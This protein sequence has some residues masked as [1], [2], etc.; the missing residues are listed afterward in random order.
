M[1]RS[2]AL[3]LLFVLACVLVAL[4]SSAEEVS[5]SGYDRLWSHVRLYAGDEGSFFQS[6]DLSGR[7]QL[8]WAYVRSDEESHVEFNVRRFRFGFRT[9]F[10]ED[11]T[12]HL[13]GEFNPQEADPVYTRITDGYLAW[14]PG[15]QAKVTLGKHS[16]GF[17][18]D[19]MTSSK[20]L[21]T[22]D[23]SNLTN[24][25]WF[26]EEYIPGVS[27][28][29]ESG[30]WNYFAGIFSSG[31]ETPEF[32]DLDGGQ[33]VLLTLGYDFAEALG[34]E[35][36]HLRGN[37]VDNEPESDDL[38][39]QPLERIGS[40]N[41]SYD[42]GEWGIR[43]DVN[44]ARG[45]AGH[46][47]LWGFW[48]MPFVR[49]VERWE[50]VGRYTFIDSTEDNGVDLARY[51]R[52]IGGGSGDRYNEVYLGANYYWYGHKL[53]LQNA[54]QYVDMRDQADDG[55]EYSGWSWTTA[56]RVYW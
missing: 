39:T 29:G 33:F 28:Q 32:G 51:E 49:P 18:L 36:A 40:I 22:I 37:Y 48:V 24:N 4:P 30:A 2:S 38:F 27:F 23:R 31:N 43:A 47:D 46:S 35:E 3:A 54:V 25:I 10:L 21:L 50:L 45:Y 1:D 44:A 26:T 8:D 20:R 41:F 56:I 9:V 52:S 13:E 55:G 42:T 16:A 14:S 34:V 5:E 7:L 6:F 12:L 17:T 19:G 53:K 15:P 11:F